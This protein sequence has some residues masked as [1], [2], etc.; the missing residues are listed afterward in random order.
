MNIILMCS[1]MRVRGCLASF[2]V[3]QINY[4]FH[5]NEAL[6]KLPGIKFEC[7]LH[8]SVK[9]DS[10]FEN[11]HYFYPGEDKSSSDI[12]IKHTGFLLLGI[13]LETTHFCT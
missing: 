12:I 11:K 4:F 3:L 2:H 5:Q 1:S 6:N 7:C 9:Q 13:M 10:P 8:F